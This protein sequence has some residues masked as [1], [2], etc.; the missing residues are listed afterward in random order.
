MASI[1]S[2][3]PPPRRQGARLAREPAGLVRRG[4][5]TAIDLAFLL[6]I[7]LVVRALLRASGEM[8]PGVDSSAGRWIQENPRLFWS[9]TFTAPAWL[10][11]SVCEALPGRAGPGKRALSLFIEGP[12]PE[13]SPSFARIALRTAIKLVPW[14]I[15]ALAFLFPTPWDPRDSLERTRF[16]VL[17]GSNLW[18]GIYMAS[19]A[20]TRRRQS[21]HDLATGTVVLGSRDARD[22]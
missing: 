9:L 19:A 16:L 6:L 14:H 4:F 11:L 20:M 12:R 17:L 8:D 15:A 22:G 10:A 3:A 7:G 21:L 1:D 5:A 13:E 2:L 18:I